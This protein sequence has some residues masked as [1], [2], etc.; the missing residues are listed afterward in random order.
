[1]GVPGPA[2]AV[3]DAL[4]PKSP[5]D[6]HAIK[7]RALNKSGSRAPQPPYCGGQGLDQVEYEARLYEDGRLAKEPERQATPRVSCGQAILADDLR[8]PRLRNINI[9]IR[10]QS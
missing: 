5:R 6:G 7:S 10:P 8:A 1:G 3:I 2:G 4:A 9:V